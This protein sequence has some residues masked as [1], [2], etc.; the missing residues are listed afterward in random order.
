M[1][2]FFK[3]RKKSGTNKFATIF[4]RSTISKELEEYKIIENITEILLKNGY[5]VIHGGYGEGAMSA[6]SDSAYRYIIDNNLPKE[7]NIAVPQKQHD[8]LWDR[9][10]NA[11]F[12]L[13]SD[14]VF[15]RLRLIT[16]GDIAVVC[17]LGGYGTELEETIIFHENIVK[18]GINK[19]GKGN[20]KLTP[21]IFFVT[22][23]G[24]DWKSIIET[25]IKYLDSS[26]KSVAEYNWLYFVDSTREFER[27]IKNIS[28]EKKPL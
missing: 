23:D 19:Y 2:N 4:G 13:A 28:H 7:L 16:S 25:K 1:N 9:V 24:T 18:M 3:L 8:G 11:T 15:D 17:P 21:L 26:V 5:G 12:T 22:K 27:V 6:V 20:E 14:D 10:K